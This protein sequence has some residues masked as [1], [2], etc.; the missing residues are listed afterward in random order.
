MR[1]TR[2]VPLAGNTGGT[3]KTIA[4]FCT[5]INPELDTT[6][7]RSAG[8]YLNL[9]QLGV[10][11]QDVCPSHEWSHR[12]VPTAPIHAV[13]RRNRMPSGSHG[14]AHMLHIKIDK[15]QLLG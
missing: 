9:G 7:R 12:E 13:K 10:C 6:T 14:Y 2:V 8:Q 11:E 4:K 5:E 15:F 3:C 1:P